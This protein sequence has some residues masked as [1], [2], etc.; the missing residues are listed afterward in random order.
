MHGNEKAISG[1]FKFYSKEIHDLI[2]RYLC[3]PITP[4]TPIGNKYLMLLVDDFSRKIWVFMLKTKDEALGIFKNFR[5]KVEKEAKKG[6]ATFRTDRGGEFCSKNF[7][8]Y[9][10][11]VDIQ[12][13]YTAPHSPQ[14]NRERRNRT[15]VAM[16]RNLLKERNIP[17]NLWGEVIRHVVYILK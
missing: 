5:K 8:S 17:V 2:R 16:G 1:T 12:R 4:S 6:I 14:Q 3:G 9:C 15:V 7:T 10:E 11:S 13:H